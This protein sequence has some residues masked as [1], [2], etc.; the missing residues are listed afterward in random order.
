MP[1]PPAATDEDAAAAPPLPPQPSET[2]ERAFSEVVS[3]VEEE[4]QDEQEGVT[5]SYYFIC[6]LHLANEHGLKLEGL[7]DL[8]DFTIS[9]DR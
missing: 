5:C 6:V 2:S 9:D 7:E 3:R 1:P 4:H 8:S